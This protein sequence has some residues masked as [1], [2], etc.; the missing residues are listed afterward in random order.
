MPEPEIHQSDHGF[1]PNNPDAP[2]VIKRFLGYSEIA[3]KIASVFPFLVTL[4]YCFFLRHTID[5][6]GSALFFLAMLLFDITVTMINNFSEFCET[7]VQKFFSRKVMLILIFCGAVPSLLIGL[8]LSWIYGLAFL[9]AGIFCFVV[10]IGYSFGPM[11]ISKSPYGELLSGLTMGFVLPFLV[12][13]INAPGL[14]VIDFAGWNVTVRLDLRGLLM[15]AFVC[16]PLILCIANIMLAN[17]IRDIE[18]DK[19][20]RYTMARHIGKANAIR[21]FAALY[22]LVYIV[23]IAAFFLGAIPWTC[24][25]VLITAVPVFRN[26][27]RYRAE[28]QK[29]ESFVLSIRNH[30]IILAPYT[31]C[32]FLGA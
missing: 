15:L 14:V 16:A 13:A 12:M 7:G 28:Q 6:R 10:G 19:A 26:V 4:A 23:I 21:L 2:G 32:I 9:L 11:P 18:T 29:P 5:V 24:L 17:N 8:Y 1:P 22:G 31:I 25:F 3:T 30:I 20:I 27:K